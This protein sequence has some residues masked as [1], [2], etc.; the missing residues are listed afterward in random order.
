[1]K[2]AHSSGEDGVA[3]IPRWAR[4]WITSASASAVAAARCSMARIGAGRPRGAISVDQSCASKPARPGVAAT[5]GTP[6]SS[7]LGVAVATAR[8]RARP[9]SA[10]GRAP[11]DGVKAKSNCPVMRSA[12]SGPPPR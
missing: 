1:M 4:A 11:E 6:G 8:M 2:A 10:C 9:A 3:S 5:G 12:I 7:G